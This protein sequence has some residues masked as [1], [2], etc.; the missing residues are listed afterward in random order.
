[1]KD[2][3]LRVSYLLLL[4]S[5]VAFLYWYPLQI[6]NAIGGFD[7]HSGAFV[8]TAGNQDL[9]AFTVVSAAVS[10][11]LIVCCIMK[12]EGRELRHLPVALLVGY[13]ATISATMW[14]EQVYANL[15]DLANNSSYWFTFY[16]LDPTKL[17]L[18][19]IDMSL[20]LV[21]QPWFRR[22]NL[23]LVALF[24]GL[25]LAMFLGWF[26]TGFQFPTDS[27]T[28]YFFNASSR[29]F[30]QAAVAVSVY[31]GGLKD[32]RIEFSSLSEDPRRF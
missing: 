13:V 10:F 28:A 24:A 26:L 3:S 2:G 15:W 18:T 20:V 8:G 19:V 30:S 5:A 11:G 23:K 17:L 9:F 14:Y 22:Q 4:V 27:G 31:P 12:R 7:I 25:T 29:L 1:M 6:I 16:Y 32:F 21:A